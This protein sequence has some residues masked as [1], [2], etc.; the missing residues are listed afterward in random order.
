MDNYHYYSL[1]GLP[2]HTKDW[3]PSEV[4]LHQPPPL[5]LRLQPLGDFGAPRPS[6]LS[7]TLPS[8]TGDIAERVHRIEALLGP[9]DTSPTKNLWF[10]KDGLRTPSSPPPIASKPEAK[11]RRCGE[12][13]E[14][15]AST[16]RG[17]AEQWG[18]APAERDG[19]G[20]PVGAG[21]RKLGRG[22]HEETSQ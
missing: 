8:P 22:E 11:A 12:E 4:P 13:R 16:E 14:G 15:G 19:D 21:G 10:Y 3:Q 1:P 17:G 18:R 9:R 20:Q 2:A 6:S 5:S 7:P